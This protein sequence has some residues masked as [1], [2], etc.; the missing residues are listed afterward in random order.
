MKKDDF[1]L[2]EL[3]VV[4][5]IIA[6]LAG[7]LLP[8]LGRARD[9][10]KSIS[11]VNNLKQIGTG[12]QM[13]ANDFD[14]FL[15]PVVPG[16]SLY[17]QNYWWN[18]LAPY[19][20]CH[21]SPQNYDDGEWKNFFTKGPYMCPSRIQVP[22]TSYGKYQCGYGIN[23]FNAIASYPDT[24]CLKLIYTS[25]IAPFYAMKA[26]GLGLRHDVRPSLLM[27]AADIN[28]ND[29]SKPGYTTPHFPDLNYWNS[30]SSNNNVAYRHHVQ[31][32][33]LTVDGHVETIRASQLY[34]NLAIIE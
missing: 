27:M 17:S 8:A 29:S 15:A 21:N 2:I 24:R 1:T 14:Y 16:E 30:S 33:I 18:I 23:T 5:A 28:Y 32:N 6:I 25:G 7:M 12:Q 26:G 9:K 3:L 31:G 22:W 34:H 4:I 13:Y 10:A 20:G 11:C 19:I